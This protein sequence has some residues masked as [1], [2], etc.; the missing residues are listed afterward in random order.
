MTDRAILQANKFGA[1]LS[2]PNPATRMTFEN[3]YFRIEPD[4]EETI[5][6][7]CLLIA[8]GAQYAGWMRMGV[9]QFE[10]DRRLLRG[11]SR[12]RATLSR[13]RRYCGGRR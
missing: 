9:E 12:R 6:T 1:H 11:Y 8:T 7:K 2:I 4:G 10:G 13:L 5:T 3:G